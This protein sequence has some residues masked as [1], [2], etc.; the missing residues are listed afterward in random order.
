MLDTNDVHFLDDQGEPIPQ[1][2]PAS[3]LLNC[4][5]AVSFGTI[6][7]QCRI[8]KYRWA[9]GRDEYLVSPLMGSGSKW[10]STK[11]IVGL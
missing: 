7:V 10:V 2:S 11:K 6:S 4:I 3:S 9:Y 1:K 8:T 5:I